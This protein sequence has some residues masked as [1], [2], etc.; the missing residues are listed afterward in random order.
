MTEQEEEEAAAKHAIDKDN[1]IPVKSTLQP[2]PVVVVDD[3]PHA[4]QSNRDASAKVSSPPAKGEFKTITH[5]LKK[6]VETKHTYKCC[7]C[8]SRKPSMHQ[9]NDHHKYHHEPQMCSICDRV[10]ALAWSLNRHMYSHEEQRY[11]RDKCNFTCHF[12]SELS[13]H[14][15][16]HQKNPSHKCMVS[17]C[18]RWF[19]QK[20]ELTSH[21]QT[22]E[23]N[24]Y[25][26]DKCD[27]SA[28][29][30]KHLKEHKKQHGNDL[31]YS[32]KICD[33]HFKYRSG[34]KRHR[35]TDHK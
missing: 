15:I 26:C 11:S 24:S 6:K 21:L 17:N 23:D 16:A 14:K 13:S 12:E 29:I 1:V 30:E 2:A 3:Q 27:F 22:H 9:L 8:G 35:D 18:G 28:K 32:C 10:F 25:K 4:S 33:K 5:A 34:L 19:K 20:W 7:V 31:P